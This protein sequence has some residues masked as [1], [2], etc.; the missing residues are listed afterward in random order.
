MSKFVEVYGMIGYYSAYA[1][2][3]QFQPFIINAEAILYVR[4]DGDYA[5]IGVRS[6]ESEHGAILIALDHTYQHVVSLLDAHVF[7]LERASRPLPPKYDAASLDSFRH[8]NASLPGGE[9]GQ[10]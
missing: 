2:E 7:H 10:S 8:E 6:S 5:N 9:V 1:S 3:K 4:Q